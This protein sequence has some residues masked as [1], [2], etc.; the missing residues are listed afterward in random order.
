MPIGITATVSLFDCRPIIS[1]ITGS[2]RQMADVVISE[3]LDEEAVDVLS[4]GF[5][6]F[7]DPDLVNRTDELHER[8]QDCRGL[9]VR[10]RT[11]VRPPLLDAA[12]NLIIVGRLGVGLDNIDMEACA[13]RDVRVQPARGTLEESVSE[14]VIGAMLVMLRQAMYGITEEVRTGTWPR[15]KVIGREAKC[16][17]L[18]LVGFGIIGREVAKRASA[19]GMRMLAYDP[20]VKEDDPLWTELGVTPASLNDVLSESDVVTLSVPR[21]DGTHHLIDGNALAKMKPDSMLINT[22]RGGVVDDAALAE[23]LKNGT[24]GN[25]FIDVFEDEPLPAGNVF[26]GVENVTL[27]PHCAGL[28]D[29]AL[30]RSSMMIANAVHDALSEK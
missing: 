7:Y 18:G 12:P 3:F 29:E 21:T 13:S 15:T 22:A 30:L 4:A 2:G 17:T 26:D 24:I 27:T 8:L 16:Q 20:Y 11:Q 23:A 19:F 9:I 25:A 5:D 1:L 14:Y 6:V 28:T 10:N